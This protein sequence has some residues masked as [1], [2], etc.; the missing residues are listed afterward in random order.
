[1]SS[2]EADPDDDAPPVSH[3]PPIIAN[4]L[5]AFLGAFFT[6]ILL[7][8]VDSSRRRKR[9]RRPSAIL[10]DAFR[11]PARASKLELET[12]RKSLKE[13]EQTLTPIDM[14]ALSPEGKAIDEHVERI[15]KKAGPHT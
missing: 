10:M 3:I 11:V 9:P 14:D 5:A 4:P 8:A 6:H 13:I 2:N 12:L 15:I 1:M 7:D